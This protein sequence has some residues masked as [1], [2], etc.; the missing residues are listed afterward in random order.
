MKTFAERYAEYVPGQDAASYHS[1]VK[2]GDTIIAPIDGGVATIVDHETGEI[3]GEISLK[4]GYHPAIEIIQMLKPGQRVELEDGMS[5]LP[6]NPRMSLMRFPHD[7]AFGTAAK[8][9]YRI[10]DATRAETSRRLA[11]QEQSAFERRQM[12]ILRRTERAAASL[13]QAAPPESEGEGE[14]EGGDA[15]DTQS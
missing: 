4:A 7:E 6:P 5:V 14:E 1:H 2:V 11:R 3:M 8:Q 10:S 13:R 12:E 9:S 15:E